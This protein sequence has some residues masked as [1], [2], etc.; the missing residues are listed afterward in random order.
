MA[1][2]TRNAS[3]FPGVEDRVRMNPGAE[4][5]AILRPAGPID[6]EVA[7]LAVQKAGRPDGQPLALYA[8]YALHYVGGNPGTDV[9]ADYFGV[10][11]DRLIELTGGPR[12]DPK[13]PFVAMLANACFGDINNNDVRT[14]KTQPH[15]YHQMFAVADT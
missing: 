9:S 3:P 14:R 2:G 5:K 11:A 10:V 6:P 4:N 15:E 13:Q 1:E 12:R 8:S 7:V